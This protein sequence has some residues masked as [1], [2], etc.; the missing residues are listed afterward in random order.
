MARNRRILL[1]EDEESLG[2]L[3]SEYLTM[4][5]FAV[6]WVKNGV[7][8]LRLLEEHDFDLL[9]IDVMMPEMDGFTLAREINE[10]YR[11][12]P[13]LF[14]TARSLKI[15][16][17][18]GFS[19][20][21][22]DY[23]KKPIDEEELVVRLN[24]LLR[25]LSSGNEG[26]QDVFEEQVQIGDYTFNVELNELRHSEGDIQKLTQRE[27]ELLLLLLENKNE[28]CAHKT[29]LNKLWGKSDFFTKKSL[30]VFISHLR[31]YLSRDPSIRIDNMHNQGFILRLKD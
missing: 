10:K 29:I 2:Y 3:L 28:L 15:D 4:K 12:T 5:D 13:F 9:V 30:N 31:K 25:T 24:T 16:V 1:V 22:V 6:K 21:A 17:L 20:G 27:S 11:G 14:L 26:D 8:A 23:L 18:K 19:L 7:Q